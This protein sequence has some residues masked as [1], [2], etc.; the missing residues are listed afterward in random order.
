MRASRKDN[1][2]SKIEKALQRIGAQIIDTSGLKNDTFDMIALFRGSTFIIEV[3]NPTDFPIKFFNFSKEEKRTYLEK[4]LTKRERKTMQKCQLSNVPF[5][6]VWD[7][8]SAF[9]AVG[10]NKPNFK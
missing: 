5:L 9:L 2:Q 1:N 4:K 8:D 10:A 3:K 6:I 7:V